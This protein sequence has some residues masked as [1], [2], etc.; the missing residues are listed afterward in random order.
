LFKRPPDAEKWCNIH[1]TTG[2]DLEEC[3]TF[4]DR[5]KI[6]LPSAS[7][8]QEARWGEQRWVDPDGDE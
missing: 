1:H 2:H 5:K 8:P 7:V 6:P 3:K 4:L